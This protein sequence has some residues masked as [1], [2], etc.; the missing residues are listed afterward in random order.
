LHLVF[1][2]LADFIRRHYFEVPAYSVLSAMINQ[3]RDTF[4]KH[5]EEQLAR[6][7]NQKHREQLD[8]LFAHYLPEMDRP[9]SGGVHP[10]TTYTNSPF[11]LTKLKVKP[12]LMK[13]KVI[14]ENV[15]DL[16]HLKKLYQEFAPILSTL[17]LGE[18]I[19]EDFAL[20]VIRASSSQV[21][22]WP[23]KSLYLMCFIQYQYFHLSDVLAETF[24]KAVEQSINRCEKE[25]KLER[26]ER[27]EQ[28][29]TQLTE[30]FGQYLQQGSTVQQMQQVA[31]DGNQN[32]LEKVRVLTTHL[33]S[34]QSTGFL[35]LL[36]S[37]QSLYDQTVPLRED[38]AYYAQ[39]AQGSQKM[40]AKVADI[41]R[42]VTLATDNSH[43][44]L[45]EAIAFFQQK[46]GQLTGNVPL[47]FLKP[48][49]QKAVKEP[50]G[51]IKV[52]LY[53]SLL[54]R[55]VAKGLKSGAVFVTTSHLHK[56]IDSYLMD[57]RTWIEQKQ[58]LLERASLR[59]IEHW[60]TV[61]ADLEYELVEQFHQTFNRIN[62][63]ENLRIKKKSDGTLQFKT[64]TKE[65]I[66]GDILNLYPTERVISL[67][68]AMETVNRSCHFLEAFELF[69]ASN[70]REKAPDK[71]FFAAIMALGC[72]LGIGRMAKTAKHISESTL[73]TTVRNYFLSSNL[74]KAND[75]I[76]A[77]MNRM[78]ISK[79]FKQ[80]P[81]TH[82]SSDGQKY[83]MELDSIHANYSSKYFGKEKGITIYSF[84]SSIHQLFY[85]T[86][87]SAGD[88]ESWYVLN[89]L[90][91]NDVVSSDVHSTD[92]H[93]SSDIVF[94]ITNLLRIDFQPRIK[95][96]YKQK[97][98]G[99]AGLTL[100]Q[101]LDFLINTG[102][103]INTDII[104]Q[105]WD[106]ILRLLVS[107]KLKHTTPSVILNRLNSY[108]LQNPLYQALKELGK[109]VRTI[110][111]L[112]YMDDEKMRQRIEGQLQKMESAQQLGKAVC[113]GNDGVLQFANKEELLVL[114]GCKR[115]LENVIICWN[116]LHLTRLLVKATPAERKVIL[117]TLP[118]ISTVAWQH[119]NL[120][121][122]FDFADDLE[123]DEIEKELEAL[124]NYKFEPDE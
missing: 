73:D 46:D 84:L 109:L 39:I 83:Y 89:G 62:N 93:G 92:T 115:L 117:D 25:Y 67:Y 58:T 43:S 96:F 10:A 48:W 38:P 100:D 60:P 2:A 123:R 32:L 22:R 9:P 76:C 37:V 23:N 95:E 50:D 99:V 102:G 49:E 124:L 14:R 118:H 75:R 105:Q 17:N 8:Q 97:L 107:L 35:E 81:K 6:Q 26:Q 106:Q 52:S 98:Y 47:D 13:V 21:K 16:Q 66:E 87:F 24:K 71:V 70:V 18:G 112:R 54:A 91:H 28:S 56:P 7:L 36:P 59:E 65:E 3:A 5:L 19:I 80:Q 31:L 94:A 119:F 1:G 104:A 30:I 103:N 44:A 72:N 101:E 41:L 20:H 55:Y 11:Q 34:E 121:G 82:T 110:F 51:K 57:E 85:S 108:A 68:E 78:S 4:E 61:K 29:L 45:G 77:L 63:G 90:F 74:E 88:R 42:H 114:E 64:P 27:Y 33:Q 122:I 120:Q 53:K 40:Q 116:Y 69:R 12:E 79:L 86:V 111:L 113:Y 15:G